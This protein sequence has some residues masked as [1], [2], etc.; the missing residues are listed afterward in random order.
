MSLS[1]FLCIDEELPREAWKTA[2]QLHHE[3]VH[4][5]W[6]MPP[7]NYIPGA[8]TNTGSRQDAFSS[9]VSFSS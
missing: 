9:L 5:A 4:P 8:P 2:R 3:K 6:A 7:E 1:G